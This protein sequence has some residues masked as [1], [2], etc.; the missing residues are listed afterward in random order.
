MSGY[1]PLAS[2]PAARSC[3]TASPMVRSPVDTRVARAGR[4]GRSCPYQIGVIANSGET[5]ARLNAAATS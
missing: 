1:A 4:P 3:R 5:P 2:N